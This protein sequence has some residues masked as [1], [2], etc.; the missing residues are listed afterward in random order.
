[1]TFHFQII[2]MA[3]RG[4][5]QNLLRTLL[6]TLGVIIG[7]GAVVSAVSILQGAE[8]DILD[9]V[10]SLGADQILVFNG[11][12]RR[13][14]RR[15]Q[16]LSLTR[17]DGDKVLEENKELVHAVAAQFNSGGQIKYYEKNVF[18]TVLGTTE[19]YESINNYHTIHGRFI[20]REDVRGDAMVAVLGNKIAQDLFGALPP[21]GKAVKINGKS[22]VV[23]GVMEE[24][25]ALGFFEV[26]NQVV[27]PLTTA[28]DRMFGQRYLTMLVAQCVDAERVPLCIDRIKRTL[29]ASHR[30]NAGGDDDFT[31]FN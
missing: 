19:E 1:M 29:R 8:K 7:V 24:K 11:S 25:G 15:T 22:F 9:R 2:M 13:S 4:L 17:E 28:M 26:D 30:I 23:V 3:L 18:G 20:T 10:E 6:A 12:D 5:N 31:V 27:I 21:E 16:T 14:A